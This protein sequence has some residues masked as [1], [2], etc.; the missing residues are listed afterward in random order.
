MKLTCEDEEQADGQRTCR[1]NEQFV[2]GGHLMIIV[3]NLLGKDGIF[4]L[5]TGII[6]NLVLV[7][8][9]CH[10]CDKQ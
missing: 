7:H 2:L 3:N 5:Q 4:D 10:C 6:P 1:N 9:S 8:S